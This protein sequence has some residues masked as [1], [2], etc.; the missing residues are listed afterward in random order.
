MNHQADY[1]TLKKAFDDA[2]LRLFWEWATL[3]AEYIDG[4]D[5]GP[6]DWDAR[7]LRHIADRLPELKKTHD[8]GRLV[9]LLDALANPAAATHAA[10]VH[11]VLIESGVSAR[12]AGYQRDGDGP[13]FRGEPSLNG[14]PEV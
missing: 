1:A 11:P 14:T 6:Q 2:L 10:A 3:E 4:D 13:P 12:D 9:R 7:F 8:H 5:V